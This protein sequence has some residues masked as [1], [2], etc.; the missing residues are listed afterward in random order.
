MPQELVRIGGGEAET[1]N[2]PLAGTFAAV[3]FIR[4]PLSLN[5]LGLEEVCT[6]IRG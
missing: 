4:F 3:G 6:R 1:L 5:M 2:G